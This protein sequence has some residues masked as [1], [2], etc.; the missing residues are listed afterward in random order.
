MKK[1]MQILR[2]LTHLNRA[3]CSIGYDEAVNALREELP[4]R[5]FCVPSSHEHNGWV[6]PPSWD[7][8]EAKIIKN[9]QTVYDGT[10]HPLGVIALSRQFQGVVDLEELRSHLHFDHRYD[11]A[12]P[13]HYRQQFRS[14]SRDWGFCIP[15]HLFDE[16]TPGDYQ[17]SIRT[18]ETS[19]AMKILEYKHAGALDFTIVLGG[20]LDHAGVSNDG[21]AGCV[22]GLELMRRLQ[23]RRTKLTYSLVLSPGIIGSEFYLAGL[24]HSERSQIIEGIFLE[25]LG[26]DTPL[27]LQESRG[28]IVS[29]THA[30]RASLDRLQVRYRSGPFGSIL[31][32]DEYIWENYGI[33]ML[34]LSRFPYPEYHSSRDNINIIR[35][36]SL[37]EAVDT[38]IGAIDELESSPII[39]K[40]FEGNICLSNPKYDLYVD[41]GQVALGDTL[42]DH[43]HRM[44]NLMDFIPALNRPATVKAVTD[45]IGVPYSEGLA[46]LE[47]WAAC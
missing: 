39:I 17:V 6:I 10:A 34:S 35:E 12:I 46:Y 37:E 29:T 18:A 26:S 1:M 44:R 23:Q 30:I 42:S 9:G 13:F 15:K 21:L 32:N 20:N 25:M 22:V 3:V 38:L 24:S 41:Y 43:Q 16:L 47:K 5:V 11:D 36:A 19:G 45:Y 8:V 27:A 7:V 40:K 31:I 33:P 14:W 4:F 28:S 2:D